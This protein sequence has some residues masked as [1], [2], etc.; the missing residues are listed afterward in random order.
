MLLN[1]DFDRPALMHGAALDWT[2]TPSAGVERRMLMRIG[3]E[4]AVATSLVRFAPGSTFGEH[5]HPGGEEFLV[6]DGVFEDESGSYPAG[7]YVRN[8]PGSRH[9]PQ[10]QRGC[11]ILVNL[12]QF[13]P[14]DHEPVQLQPGESWPED[15]VQPGRRLL[16]RSAHEEVCISSTP[17]GGVLSLDNPEGLQLLL[18]EGECVVDERP[19]YAMSWLRLPAGHALSLLAG[20][21]GCRAWI[22]RAAP[23][24]EALRRLGE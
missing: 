23:P 9:T 13:P 8:P 1:T 4:K 17:P 14:D 18:L 6:L 3:E 11:V 12:W 15:A 21:R 22:K 2:V 16:Y 7:S 10:A 5:F 24:E 20:P 19:L